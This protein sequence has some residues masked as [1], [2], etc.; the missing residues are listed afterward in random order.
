MSAARSSRASNDVASPSLLVGLAIAVVV[1]IF[2]GMFTA[3]AQ[4]WL[5][6]STGSLANSAGPWSLAAFLVARYNRR[7]P[8]AVVAAVLTLACCEL[9]YVIATEIR[10]G[11]TATST[12][13]FWLT[14]AVFAGPPLGVAGAWASGRGLRRDVGFAVIA[15]VL[16]GEGIYGWTTIADTTDWRYWAVE[17]LIGVGLAVALAARSRR[18][19]NALAI[20]ATAAVTAVVVFSAARLV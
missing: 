2:V 17:T 9:G 15:G 4:G 13:A 8:A 3:Y 11:S 20:I 12:V 18:V 10:G 1:G 16:I 5:D 19:S 6:D 14:A 7:L